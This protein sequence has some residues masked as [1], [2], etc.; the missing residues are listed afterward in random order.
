M[1]GRGRGRVGGRRRKPGGG[2]VGEAGGEPCDGVAGI[3]IGPDGHRAR[4]GVCGAVGLGWAEA[5]GEQWGR[6]DRAG[7]RTQIRGVF[8]G[9]GFHRGEIGPDVAGQNKGGVGRRWRELG[10]GFGPFLKPVLASGRVEPAGAGKAAGVGQS[11]QR[12]IAGGEQFEDVLV[13]GRVEHHGDAGGR[14][15]KGGGGGGF[16][17]EEEEQRKLD[18]EYQ[19][20][21][22]DPALPGPAFRMG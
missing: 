6:Q 16:F 10:I 5:G 22:G 12:G 9:R 18:A 17:R 13:G 4:E 14:K 19:G 3:K 7:E 15:G 8:D 1:V 11:E 21:G 2:G 20:D